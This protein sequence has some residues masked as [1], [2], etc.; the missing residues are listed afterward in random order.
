MVGYMAFSDT[1][2]VPL[3]ID[4]CR[5]DGSRLLFRGP[6]RRLEG[7]FAAFLGGT[8]TF[9]KFISR[10]FPDLV[11]DLTGITCVNFGWPNAGI[12][13]FANDSALIDCAGRAEVCVLQVP[14][15]I[16]MSNMYY[17]VHPRRNDRFVQATDALKLLFYEVDFTEFS[18]TRHMLGHLHA[19]SPERFSYI[20]Q[21]LAAV[22]VPGMRGLLR[23]IGAPV[24]LLW[25]SARA[26]EEVSDSP[27]L[28]AD[29]A[30]VSREMLEALRGDVHG[31]VELR[32]GEGARG[33]DIGAVSRSRSDKRAAQGLLGPDAH[34]QAAEALVPVLAEI[35]QQ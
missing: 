6:R 22:W 1:G 19:L 9:G 21:E 7:E 33:V 15:A 8:E 2:H 25:L 14:C 26:P 24:I 31:I 4:Q 32:L 13:V 30:L 23:Q 29:P 16:N 20:C 28:E 17:R 12:D 10:P 35:L 34:T 5:Y 27:E 3:T 11:E 18:F